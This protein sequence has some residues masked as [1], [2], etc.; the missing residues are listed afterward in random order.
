MEHMSN[1]ASGIY[2]IVNECEYETYKQ[3]SIRHAVL[4]SNGEHL[5]RTGPPYGSLSLDVLFKAC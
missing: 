4:L 1:L 2:S 5:D 3:L